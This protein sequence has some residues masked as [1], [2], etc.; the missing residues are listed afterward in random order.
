MD[1]V[2]LCPPHHHHQPKNLAIRPV[3]YKLASLHTMLN[4]RMDS[5]GSVLQQRDVKIAKL[6][7]LV[8]DHSQKLR[9][10]MQDKI[11]EKK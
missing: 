11:D 2:S 1:R 3:E 8:R 6:E 5:M 9:M 4:T 10:E 7:D